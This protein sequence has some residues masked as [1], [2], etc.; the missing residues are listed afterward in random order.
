MLTPLP[1][2]DDVRE[3][4]FRIW[5][6]VLAVAAVRYGPQGAETLRFKQAAADLLWSVCPRTDRAERSQVIQKLPDI[7]TVLREGMALLGI[8]EHE[9]DGHLKLLNNAVM[10][11]F[12][13]QAEAISQSTLEELA[14]G[15]AGL[16]DVVTDDPQGDVLL[17]PGAIELMFGIQSDA[18]EVIA[19]GGSQP[20]EGMLQWAR[21]LE[22]G[23]WFS[24]DLQ[25][26]LTQVQ[27]VWRSA[28]GQLHLL[29]NSAGKNYLV[30]TRRLAS[31]LQA[32]L[33]TPVEDEALTVRATREALAKLN[34]QPDQLLD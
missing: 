4:L 21:E 8:A 24:L 20:T 26:A 6:E 28:R 23:A 25:G 31:Y 9:Q 10:Q 18:L 11:A 13:S 30:Q 3:F 1:V 22:L 15:L 17:D 34:A 27:Y 7:L 5:S 2:S 29:A 14:R 33:L 32:G 12:V 16:E 19:T